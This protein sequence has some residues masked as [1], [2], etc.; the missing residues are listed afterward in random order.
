M[1][2]DSKLNY[3]NQGIWKRSNQKALAGV[4]IGGEIV[5][6]LWE[7]SDTRLGRTFYQAIDASIVGAV[8]SEVLKRTFRRERPSQTDDPND[9]FKRGGRSFPSGEV[10][11][12]ASVV[13]PFVLEYGHDHP[14]VYALELIPLY[15]AQARMKTHGHWQTDVLAGWALGTLA[16]Y[17][18][19]SR[20]ESFTVGFVPRGISVGWKSKF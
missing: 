9:W 14:A 16:G 13:T 5:G 10:T 4:L 8:S 7:G 11:L 12:A 18:A 2:I 20:S 3:D 15:D 1:G 19:H 17:Y 6:A